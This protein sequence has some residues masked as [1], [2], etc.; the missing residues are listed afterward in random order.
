MSPS[1]EK[2]VTTFRTNA[3]NTIFRNFFSLGA[4]S[5]LATGMPK[6]ALQL[7][8]N[9]TIYPKDLDTELTMIV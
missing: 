6:S 3:D 7:S 8:A 4:S 2:Q 5:L 1:A 9:P